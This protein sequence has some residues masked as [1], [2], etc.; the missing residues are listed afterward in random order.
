MMASPRRISRRR[1]S[2]RANPGDAYDSAR[3][4]SLYDSLNSIP[5][6]DALI[7]GAAHES[8]VLEYKTAS[9]PFDDKGRREIAKDV[10]AMAN[11]LGGVIIYGVATDRTIKSKPV[12]IEDIDPK[13][14]ATFDQVVNSQVP[15]PVSFRKKLIPPDAPRVMV[16]DIAASEDPPHQSL[17]DKRYYRRSGEESVPMEHD[18]VAMHFGRRHGPS[19]EI[20]FERYDQLEPYS[21]EPPTSKPVRLRV[22]IRNLE[23][24]RLK[25][26][27]SRHA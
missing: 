25:L 20:G 21:G 15:P 17:A 7:Q 5:D 8:Q 6:I 9:D 24:D 14:I 10:S 18:L 3:V 26:T 19:L 22:S 2:R 16:V 4:T 13:C 27:H 11:S 23:R 12:R 1:K